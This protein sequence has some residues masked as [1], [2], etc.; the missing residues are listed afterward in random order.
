MEKFLNSAPFMWRRV[1]TDGVILDCNQMYADKINFSKDEIIGKSI[2]D[3]VSQESVANLQKAFEAWK[4][5]G[6]V[7]NMEIWLK[8]KD[9][10]IFPVLLSAANAYDESGALLGSN[11]V[12]IDISEINEEKQ[13]I[14][15]PKIKRLQVIGELTSRI[16]HDIRNPL[17]MIKNGL[18]M[19]RIAEYQ[20]T[21]DRTRDWLER[22]GRGVERINY[23]VENVLDYVSPRP[24]RLV[25]STVSKIIGDS[26]EDVAV[27][28]TVKIQVI[29]DSAIQC[30]TN[31][32]QIVFVNLISNAIQAM[33]G[34]GAITIQ[35]AQD[36]N[37]I[38]ITV[39]DTGPGIPLKNMS[40]IF[41]PLFTTRQIGTGLGLPSCKAILEQHGGS[42]EADTEA[43][44][45]CAV[46]NQAAQNGV[47][48]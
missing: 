9:G 15:W 45:I 14:H 18:E 3:H 47:F 36:G 13:V 25:E 24:L 22:I 44:K 23:Q 40:K 35:T 41:D 6:A 16:S 43:W 21:S 2:F 31:K 34:V 26:I 11:T 37:E 5:A 33:S 19:I 8:R 48:G 7:H 17:A 42:I 29:G 4:N 10:T 39:T 1:N 20:N 28:D 38:K 30:D 32:I 46:Y 27:P 12:M